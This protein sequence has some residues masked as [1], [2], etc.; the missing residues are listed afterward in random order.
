M[1]MTRNSPE[2]NPNTSH[3]TLRKAYG[4]VFNCPAGQMVL[5]DICT[6]LN[7][8]QWPDKNIA[9]IADSRAFTDGQRSVALRI[10]AMLEDIV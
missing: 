1:K 9:D 4:E 7:K 5:A 3:A 8:V 10:S 6:V 2:R